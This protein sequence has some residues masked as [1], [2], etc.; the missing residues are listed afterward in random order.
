MTTMSYRPKAFRQDKPVL[1]PAEGD[2][3]DAARSKTDKKSQPDKA[4]SA[5]RA[6]AMGQ[7]RE[8]LIACRPAQGKGKPNA[9]DRGGKPV[10]G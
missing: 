7:P 3:V 2:M 4:K 8:D 1:R 10:D 6:A 9:N 5:A